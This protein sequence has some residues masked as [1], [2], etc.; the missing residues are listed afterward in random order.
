MNATN[1]N[2]NRRVLT[3]HETLPLTARTPQLGC[4][5]RLPE[6][7]SKPTQTF[8]RT[9]EFNELIEEHYNLNDESLM[10]EMLYFD[11]F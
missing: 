1:T 5:E 3:I 10:R 4:A 2:W 11:R 8:S 9:N 6:R 7:V